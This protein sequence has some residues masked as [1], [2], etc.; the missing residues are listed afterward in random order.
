MTENILICNM[1]IGRTRNDMVQSRLWSNFSSA[2]FMPLRDITHYTE[3][4]KMSHILDMVLSLQQDR[5][6]WL[7]RISQQ[8]NACTAYFSI[9][10]ALT[11][12]NHPCDWVLG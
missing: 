9:L 1:V 8:P 7:E 2:Y 5:N 11:H 10:V 3:K 6:T 4:L 12:S